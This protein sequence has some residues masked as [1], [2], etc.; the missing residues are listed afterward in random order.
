[1]F[2]KVYSGGLK[3][4]EGYVV[5]VEADVSDGLPGFHMVGYLSSEV[6][7][8]EERVRSAMKN[9]GF[10]LPPAKITVNLSPANVRKEGT[11]YDLPVAVAV[12]A[13][14]GVVEP[15][16]LK[17]SAFLGE[18]GLDGRIKPVLGVLPMVIGM[19]GNGIRRC[20]LTEENVREGLAVDGI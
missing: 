14:C 20:F 8:A 6:K 15:G 17:D 2:S 16:V 13:S 10:R 4:I 18:L 12:L 11:A 1:M 5:Q 9:S 19:S 3:G 7:E